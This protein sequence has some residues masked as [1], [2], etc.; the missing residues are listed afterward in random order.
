[1]NGSRRATLR[2]LARDYR[3]AIR[4]QAMSARAPRPLVNEG[5]PSRHPVLL[6]P[7]VWETSGFLGALEQHLRE[8]GHRVHTLPGLGF[9]LRPIDESAEL[10]A[11]YL[12]RASLE[13]VIIVAHSKGGL[14]GKRMLLSAPDR[15]DKLI[16]IATPFA[17]SRYADYFIAPSLRAFRPA[18]ASL[19]A[20]AAER[21]ANS[22]IVSIYP[23]VDP[24]IPEGSRLERA[25][26]VELPLVGHFRLLA[27]PLLLAA[28]DEHLD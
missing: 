8:R 22:R 18:N 23:R 12:K 9:N 27:D 21:E 10:G 20:L 3:W 2:E 19:R 1:M 6:I 11:E 13:H 5:D 25:V 17:G 24:H 14:I 28:I 4:Q 16:A 15:V 7:G 26:N